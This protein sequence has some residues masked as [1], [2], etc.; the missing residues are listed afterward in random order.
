MNEV[1]TAGTF[2]P[3]GRDFVYFGL[4]L[5]SYNFYGYTVLKSIY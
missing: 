4:P 5:V 3:D 1:V 2:T